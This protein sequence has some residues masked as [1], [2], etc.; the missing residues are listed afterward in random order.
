MYLNNYNSC[1]SVTA[2]LNLTREFCEWTNYQSFLSVQYSIKY[3]CS[4]CN[5]GIFEE[6]C[7]LFD[8]KRKY[9]L[10]R[11]SKLS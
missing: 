11:L 9:V 7:K 5:T 1:I 4:H 6:H 3:I 8:Y 2:L 10:F